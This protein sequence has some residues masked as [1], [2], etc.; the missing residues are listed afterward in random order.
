MSFL[1]TRIAYA[2]VVRYAAGMPSAR[3]LVNAAAVVITSGGVFNHP[4]RVSGAPI[5][6][7]ATITDNT[8]ET[9]S[10]PYVFAPRLSLLSRAAIPLEMMLVRPAGMNAASVTV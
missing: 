9:I 10:A 1:A 5:R 8:N 7:P 4:S 6:T 3:I 2:A